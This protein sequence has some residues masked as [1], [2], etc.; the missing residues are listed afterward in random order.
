MYDQQSGTKSGL[1]F[2]GMRIF[3]FNGRVPEGL[4]EYKE[5]HPDTSLRLSLERLVEANRNLCEIG[6]TLMSFVWFC[7]V[8]TCWVW[9]LPVLSLSLRKY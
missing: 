6:A 5:K 2:R 4:R 7:H 9:C 1:D 3:C 8:F